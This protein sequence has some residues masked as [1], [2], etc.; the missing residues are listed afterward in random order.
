MEEAFFRQI[1]RN[2]EALIVDGELTEAYIKCKEILEKHPNQKGIIDLKKEIE[3]RMIAENQEIVKAG[4]KEVEEL[5][6][7]NNKEQALKKLKELLNL[8]PNNESLKRMYLKIQKRY[9]NEL[10][11]AQEVFLNR[12]TEELK[13]LMD[14]DDM[15]KL[16]QVLQT[17][18][19]EYRDNKEIQA[20]AKSYREK[21]VEKEIR[22]KEELLSSTKFDDIDGFLN[23]LKKIDESSS[24]IK[25]VE[26]YIRKRKMGN[27][28]E[29]VEEFIFSSEDNLIT[30]MKLK[31]YEEAVIVA[32]EILKTSPENNNVKRI[33]E[34]AK[35]KAFFL[36]QK[37][38]VRRIFQKLPALKA[39]YKKNKAGFISLGACKLFYRLG[40]TSDYFLEQGL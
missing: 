1:R 18:S 3:K 11:K 19:R 15:T 32:N 23:D 17:F 2:I 26:A 31:K 36:N 25:N 38:T 20:L 35:R 39:E 33:L 12:K 37:E 5:N 8:S 30:L 9:K 28:V 16:L 29:N 21:I 13:K 6:K 4:I 24:A 40:Q 10:D 27:Q 14:T 7:K 34:K 22:K